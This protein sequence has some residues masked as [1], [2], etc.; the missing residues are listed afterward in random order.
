MFEFI[1]TNLIRIN[2]VAHFVCV[3]IIYIYLYM[4]KLLCMCM[5]VQNKLRL[6]IHVYTCSK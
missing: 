2:Y 6:C 4:F 3:Y 5:H 1:R